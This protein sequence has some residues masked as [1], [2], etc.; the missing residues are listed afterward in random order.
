M[1]V[2]K[3][4]MKQGLKALCIWTAA[5]SLMLAV[6]IFIFPEMKKQM[7]GVTRLFANM[8]SFTKAFGM[9]QLN[10]GELIGFYGIECGNILGICCG[11]YAAFL[12]V[13]VLSREEKEHTAEFLMSHP[14]S[15]FSVVLQKLLSVTVQ[16][17]A[18]NLV[19]LLVSLLSIR[20]IGEALPAKEF[21][22]IH[23]VYVLLQLEIAFICF[24]ISAFTRRGSIGIGLGLAAV[25]YFMDLICNLSEKGE[26]L[27]YVTPFSYAKPADIVSH[28]SLNGGL[29]A[30]GILYAAVG[31]IAGFA[32]YIRKDLAA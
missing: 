25:L 18:M 6:C 2:F 21:L 20:L 29:A 28:L 9:D 11:F 16:L 27:K 23:G 26:F 17:L 3:K 8:G 4:E 13:S 22:L 1:A 19:I 12:G 32:K 15:R 7:E 31:V 10:F 5:V 30:L 24:G 14:V